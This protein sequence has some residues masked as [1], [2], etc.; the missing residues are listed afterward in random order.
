MDFVTIRLS[1]LTRD[2]CALMNNN[3]NVLLKKYQ[4]RLYRQKLQEG[5]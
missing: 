5:C 1:F 2:I 4:L 3:L